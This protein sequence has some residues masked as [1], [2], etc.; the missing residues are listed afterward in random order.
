MYS[1]LV[2][3]PCSLLEDAVLRAGL[4][5]L[6]AFLVSLLLGAK[7]I[8]RLEK[9]QV[10]EDT[11]KTHSEVLR[12]LH[13]GKKDTPTMGG[14]IILL[15]LFLSAALWCNLWNYSVKLVFLTAL[16][17]GMLGFVDD[18]LKL[19][20]KNSFGMKDKTKLAFQLGLGLALGIILYKHFGNSG[21]GTTIDLPFL[22]KN[23]ELGVLYVV[24]V[25]FYV[26]WSSNAVNLTDGLDGL[27]TGCMILAALVLGFMAFVVGDREVSH[28]FRV[29]YIPGAKELSV[30]CAALM[31]SGLG[32]LW[33]N[34]Y[35]AQAFMGDVGS[36]S[37][38]GALAVVALLLKQEC[39]FLLVGMVFMMEAFSVFLQVVVYKFSGRRVF[40]CAPL[41]HHFQFMGWPE[42][43][44]TIRLWILAAAMGLLGLLI[45]RIG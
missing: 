11:S 15:A 8:K 44:I 30:F 18:Y 26:A 36:L 17:L 25:M 37:V 12:E 23:L 2:E 32:F 45:L 31:G 5:A 38:G 35:P 42:T 16:V 41:H 9:Y 22:E 39:L 28:F 20:I 21:L 10:K 14:I 6:T 3:T 33:Y 7:A 43:K 1:Y 24:L 40:Y 29:N 34:G 19:T 4:A 27:A 13:A